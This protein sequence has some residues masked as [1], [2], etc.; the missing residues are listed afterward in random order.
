[1]RNSNLGIW[2]GR[3]GVV[4]RTS[5]RP[6]DASY[7][8]SL[9]QSAELLLPSY[10]QAGTARNRRLSHAVVLH[11]CLATDGGLKCSFPRPVRVVSTAALCTVH[12][13]RPS[14]SNCARACGRVSNATDSFSYGPS[15]GMTV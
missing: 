12:S 5:D 8:S 6:V 4:F 10:G 7:R 11:Y 9:Y 1:M 3:T 14:A 13:Y 15:I 2:S